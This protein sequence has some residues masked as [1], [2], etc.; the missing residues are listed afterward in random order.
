MSFTVAFFHLG[1]FVNT[2]NLKYNG[3]GKNV[4]KNVDADKW[5]FFQ[6]LGIVRSDLGYHGEVQ[7]WWKL[8]ELSLEDGLFYFVGDKDASL[9][10]DCTKQYTVMVIQCCTDKKMQRKHLSNEA[11]QTDP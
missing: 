3:H 8:K 4:Y 11:G 7:M 5:S 9:L 10:S 1:H 2:P 6:A